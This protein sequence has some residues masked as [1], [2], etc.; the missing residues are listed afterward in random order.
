[1]LVAR[2][3]RIGR[4]QYGPGSGLG[5]RDTIGH[6]FV[7]I[8]KGQV[9]WTCDG[10]TAD[11]G[12]GSFVLSQPGHVEQYRWDPRGFTQHDYIH[13][14]LTPAA[15]ATLPPPASWPTTATV[16][17]HDVLHALFQHLIEVHRSG[18]AQA[19]EVVRL[20]VEQMLLTWVHGLSGFT[21]RGL[22]D[23]PPSLQQVIDLIHG[24]WRTGVFA[25]PSLAAMAVHAGVSRS[26]LMR[27]FDQHFGSGPVHFFEAQRL[28][29]GQL[30]LLESNLSV[31]AI[32][33]RLG[34][35]NPFQ[36]SRGFKARY[37][38]SPRVFRSRPLTD[39]GRRD[40]H[41]FQWVFEILSATQTV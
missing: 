14:D 35:P 10:L 39:V 33:E 4:V 17:P 24:R 27:T 1:M 22:R 18:H 29:F 20:A 31:G 16:E 7:R 5:P 34:Y 38:L 30:L 3:F 8:L 37:R 36:F 11:L 25:P 13:F 19:E 9:Q 12:P 2:A 6:E 26:T 40:P 28:H 21:G 41:A 23:V 15:A 32:A